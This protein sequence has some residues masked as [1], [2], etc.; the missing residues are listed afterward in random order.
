MSLWK[1]TVQALDD[2]RIRIIRE[3]EAIRK[4]TLHNAFMELEKRL[5]FL[6]FD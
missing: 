4:E 1:T 3:I 6:Y 5:N 2:A